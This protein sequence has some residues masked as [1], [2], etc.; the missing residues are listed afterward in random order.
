MT[1]TPGV[2]SDGDLFDVRAAI[3]RVYHDEADHLAVLRRDPPLA[4]F[5]PSGELFG[6]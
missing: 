4:A 3:D 2:G 6:L 1:A 5:D